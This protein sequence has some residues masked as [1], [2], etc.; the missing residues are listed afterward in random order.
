MVWKD[1]I[2]YFNNGIAINWN[3]SLM[4]D[5]RD[6]LFVWYQFSWVKGNHS[7]FIYNGVQICLR[8]V[9]II[10][11]KPRNLTCIKIQLF[12]NPGKLI[13]TKT[14]EP[15]VV[16]DSEEY[17]I[18][19]SYIYALHLV[20]LL[21]FNHNLTYNFKKKDHITMNMFTKFQVNVTIMALFNYL[22]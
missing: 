17:C 5:T 18:I 14:N 12:I 21:E 16:K 9:C 10:W 13:P 7:F 2:I 22:K 15:T 6:S 1:L 8:F 11:Q 3:T 19:T 4:C 20:L